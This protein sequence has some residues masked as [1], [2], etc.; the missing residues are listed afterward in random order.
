MFSPLSFL[1]TLPSTK[2]LE[3]SDSSSIIFIL[4]VTAIGKSSYAFNLAR[5]LSCQIISADAYQVYKGMDIG[6]AK[7]KKERRQE[8]P[9]HIIDCVEPKDFFDVA[10]F[11]FL[12]KFHIEECLKK[13]KRVIIVGG[14]NY[15]I[16]S[17]I[18]GLYDT[19]AFRVSS[20]EKWRSWMQNKEENS[21][22]QE[23]NRI[24]P[25][26]AQRVHQHDHYRLIRVLDVFESTQRPLSSFQ[27]CGGIKGHFSYKKIGLDLD[28]SLLEERVRKRIVLMT[29]EGFLR[30]VENLIKRGLAQSQSFR[31]ALGY[32]QAQEVLEGRRSEEDFY[33][34]LFSETKKLIKKQKKWLKR[35]Q[36]IRWIRAKT[37]EALY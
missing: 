14:S 13:D 6:T 7:P 29:K 18:E 26:S 16:E 28:K 17:L 3:V 21:L 4:G 31:T 24:D 34:F 25:L 23:V 32:S 20:K 30:E 19:P 2:T 15:Y 36:E 10:Q 37:E 8:I 1:K 5:K 35:D 11:V 22:W 27:R 9:H 12:A 33:Y